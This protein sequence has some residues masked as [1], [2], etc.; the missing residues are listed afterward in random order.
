VQEEPENQGA[1]GFVR[2]RLTALLGREPVYVGREAA[3]SPATGNHK[4]HQEE[5]RALV[6]RALDETAEAAA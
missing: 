2:P 4:V 6:A 3:A 5:E 1:W